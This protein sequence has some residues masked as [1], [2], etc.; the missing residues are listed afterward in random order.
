MALHDTIVALATGAVNAPVAILRISGP[1]V[2]DIKEKLNAADLRPN[3]CRLVNFCRENGEQI[4]HGLLL[5]FKGPNSFTGEDILEFQGHGNSIIIEQL[6]ELLHHWGV[7]LAEPGEFSKRAFLNGKMDLTQAEAICDLINAGSRQV[8]QFA[9]RSLQGG[10]SR[11]INQ[12]VDALTRWRIHLEASIDFPEEAEVTDVNQAQHQFFC[13][14]VD[15]LLTQTLDQANQGY[16]L[17][18]TN[19]VAFIGPPN[20]GKST[21]FNRLLDRERAI[22]TNIPGTTRDV[23]TESCRIGGIVFTLAD[24]AGI[25]STDD[26][27]E[28][29]GIEKSML[30]MNDSDHVFILLD[31]SQHRVDMVND[32]LAPLDLANRSYH[33]IMNKS[34]L[35]NRPS[36]WDRDGVLWLSAKDPEADS[37]MEEAFKQFCSYDSIDVPFLA[38]RRH[39]EQ[40]E[41]AREVMT[42]VKNTL[43]SGSVDDIILS[44]NLRQI[45]LCLG[46]ITGQVSIDDLLDR[47]FSE[48]CMGK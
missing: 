10:F 11:Q 17:R 29:I 36:G 27:V 45:Q 46:E 41:K 1:A 6:L 48:F 14:Q 23:V 33:I 8:A 18:Q 16:C 2:V 43:A 13:Q 37:L 7:R 34:D 9:V 15:E 12:L 47:I 5:F 38:R 20:A 35:I 21:W 39:L 19:Q 40:L 31:A 44:E 30:T 28:K 26:V 32:V 3:T 4:D 24:T 22:V 25:H 42:L